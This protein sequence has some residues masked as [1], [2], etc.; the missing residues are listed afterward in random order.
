MFSAFE[1][2]EGSWPDYNSLGEDLKGVL[3][4]KIFQFTDCFIYVP[5]GE[6][7]VAIQSDLELLLYYAKLS[8]VLTLPC[9]MIPLKHVI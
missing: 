8:P 5:K 6:S 3:E 7:Q 9:P 1:H 4:K 2:E